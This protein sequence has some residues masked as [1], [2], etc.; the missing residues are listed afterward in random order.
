M[1]YYFFSWSLLQF[2][3]KHSWLLCSLSTSDSGLFTEHIINLTENPLFAVIPLT[4]R[5]R[6]AIIIHIKPTILVYKGSS[7]WINWWKQTYFRLSQFI[8]CFPPGFSV[9]LFSH[10]NDLYWLISAWIGSPENVKFP[11]CFIISTFYLKKGVSL[12]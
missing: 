11:D 8:E 2:A 1:S 9:G 4:L 6:R 5:Y 3:K 7:Q 10:C 12:W